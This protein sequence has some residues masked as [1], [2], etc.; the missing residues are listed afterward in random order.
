MRFSAKAMEKAVAEGQEAEGGP[1]PAP[2]AE[3][4]KVKMPGLT[5]RLREGVRTTAPAGA[6][7]PDLNGLMRGFFGVPTLNDAEFGDRRPRDGGFPPD[8]I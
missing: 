7:K 4:A 5:A 8:E 1:A 2:L 3:S 6:T